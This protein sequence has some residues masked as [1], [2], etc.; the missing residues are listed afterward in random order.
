[1]GKFGIGFSGVSGSSSA[2]VSSG[3]ERF[4]AT[5]GQKIFTITSF[6]A[7]DRTLVFSDTVLADETEYTRVGNVFTFTVGRL[8]GSLIVFKN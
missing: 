4:V 3:M 2:T 5:A 1:M 6:T 8:D 7:T